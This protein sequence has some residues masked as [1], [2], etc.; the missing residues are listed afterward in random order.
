MVVRPEGVMKSIGMG[1]KERW[2]KTEVEMVRRRDRWRTL[3][4]RDDPPVSPSLLVGENS[5][6]DRKTAV[7]DSTSNNSFQSQSPSRGRL[8]AEK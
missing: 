6:E 4:V 1:K 8:P 5:P 3:G 2:R 7:M